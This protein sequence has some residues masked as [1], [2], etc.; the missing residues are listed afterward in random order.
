MRHP[1]MQDVH[2]NQLIPIAFLP[3]VISM[4]IALFIL[5]LLVVGRLDKVNSL[6]PT[7]VTPNTSQPTSQQ[8]LSKSRKRA[9]GKHSR[10]SSISS[11]TSIKIPPQQSPQSPPMLS[12]TPTKSYTRDMSYPSSPTSSMA[13]TLVE[14]P[15]IR[16]SFDA[17][18]VLDVEATC[19][20]GVGFDFPNE[21]IVR[22]LFP[23][24]Y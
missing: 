14:D 21:I 24:I 18:L 1:A 5:H 2:N 16:Q 19:S 15:R 22:S 9:K 7:P 17:L 12:L 6:S 3:V 13:E 8:K 11:T 20:Q 10:N 23:A 4:P